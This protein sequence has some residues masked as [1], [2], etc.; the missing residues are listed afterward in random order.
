MFSCCTH[1]SKNPDTATVQLA[2]KCVP[3]PQVK[4]KISILQER[5]KYISESSMQA[6]R[7]NS[8]IVTSMLMAEVGHTAADISS[9]GISASLTIPGRISSYSFASFNLATNHKHLNISRER[10]ELLKKE[11]DTLPNNETTQTFREKVS[12]QKIE[13]KK[14]FRCCL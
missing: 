3:H 5:L 7:N 8:L 9:G 11:L 12:E 1:R 14:E 6:Q 13:I 4:Q 10:F 2:D